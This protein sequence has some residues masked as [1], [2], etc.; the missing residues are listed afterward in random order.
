[1]AIYPARSSRNSTRATFSSVFCAIY[2]LEIFQFEL[3]RFI[4]I[5]NIVQLELQLKLQIDI[6]I[7]AEITAKKAPEGL[8]TKAC[9]GTTSIF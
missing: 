5:I 6:I 2:Q 7:T 8:G 1:M 3:K 9:T 4:V